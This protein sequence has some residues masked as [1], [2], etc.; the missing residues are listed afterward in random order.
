MASRTR[1]PVERPTERGRTPA[2]PPLEVSRDVSEGARST[3]PERRG[4]PRPRPRI[5][6]LFEGEPAAGRTLFD[7]GCGK[8]RSSN[9]LRQLGFEVTC[10]V[11]GDV[12]A[13]EEG[14]RCLRDVDL[15]RRLPVED[16]SFDCA[17]L[18]EVFEHLENPVHTIREFNR[19]LKPGGLWAMTVPNASCLRSRVHFLVSGFVR[20]RWR[21][22]DYDTPP[23]EY[24]NIFIPALPSLHY[25]TWKYG[26]RVVRTGRG[27]RR[28]SSYVWLALLWPVIWLRSRRYTKPLRRFDN[29][30]QRE[31]GLDL[32]RLLLSRHVLL[33]DNLILLFRK[34]HGIEGLYDPG[35]PSGG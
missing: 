34:E 3:A 21:S 28:L 19:I 16:E 7:A 1:A 17:A 35:S 33:D 11:Y 8:G 14:I 9:A 12:P 32:R 2:V 4:K 24:K 13:L 10:S 27:R 26:F 18:Q 15:N 31:A 22:A 6:Q 30:G 29:P 5:V 23:G 25:L 20:G